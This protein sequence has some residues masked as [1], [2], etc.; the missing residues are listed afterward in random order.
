LLLQVRVGGRASIRVTLNAQVLVFPEP[1]VAVNVTVVVPVPVINVPTEGDW[2]MEGA[3]AQLS[4][5]VARL[6]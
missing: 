1:S 2:A 6:V 3:G 5:A 4:V